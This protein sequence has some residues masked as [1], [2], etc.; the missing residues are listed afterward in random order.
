MNERSSSYF[1]YKSARL[2]T[3]CY[4][5]FATL[6]CYDFT[7]TLGKKNTLTKNIEYNCTGTVGGRDIYGLPGE[8]DL[9]EY[10]GPGVIVGH[11]HLV[12]SGQLYVVKLIT[13]SQE[14]VV[15]IEFLTETYIQL[16]RIEF[17]INYTY[18][19]MKKYCCYCYKTSRHYCYSR[20]KVV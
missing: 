20:L 15:F 16:R 18:S 1:F 6:R 5:M 13:I 4:T 17:I 3:T 9:V 14:D 11:P 10:V 2:W 12:H 19:C 7:Q 8:D